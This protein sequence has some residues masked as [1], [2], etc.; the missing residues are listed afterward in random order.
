MIILKHHYLICSKN[1]EVEGRVILLV[2]FNSMSLAVGSASL[3]RE[4]K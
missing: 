4:Q 3:K 2:V 1:R